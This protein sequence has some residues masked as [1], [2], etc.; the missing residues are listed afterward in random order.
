MPTLTGL[1]A[2]RLEGAD[3]VGLEDR[4]TGGPVDRVGAEQREVALRLEG[5]QGV[6]AV[7]ELVVAQRRRVVADGVHGLGHRVHGP[8][9]DRVDLGVVVGQRRAL[10]RVAGVE[11]ERVGRP[12]LGAHRRHQGGDLGQADVVVGRVVVLGVLEV[13]PVEDVAV[14][15]RRAQHGEP[16]PSWLGRAGLRPR[17]G[18]GVR[19]R[20]APEEGGA[21]LRRRRRA[22]ASRD[23]CAPAGRGSWERRCGGGRHDCLQRQVS[24][25]ARR[26]ARLARATAAATWRGLPP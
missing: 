7:V 21:R 11:Q 2:A 17:L 26:A 4:G 14:G 5:A 23:G 1:P 18:R 10:D 20:R 8:A 9:G 16:E 6:E 3:D 13:V 24:Q 19:P 12:P 22:R 25:G 15:V